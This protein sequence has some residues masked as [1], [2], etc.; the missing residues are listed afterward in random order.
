MVGHS[1]DEI[2][3]KNIGRLGIRDSLLY[4]HEQFGLEAPYL[5]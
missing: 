5:V 2:I 3:L 1:L 4:Q